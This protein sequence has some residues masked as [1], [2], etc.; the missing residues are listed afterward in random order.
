MKR[1]VRERDEDNGARVMKMRRE[2]MMIMERVRCRGVREG[3][4]GEL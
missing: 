4:E 1:N 2:M 3:C